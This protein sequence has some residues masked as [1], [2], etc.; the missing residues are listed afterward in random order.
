MNS[1]N[2]I[3]IKTLMFA[4]L[5]KWKTMVAV[6]V[7]LAIALGGFQGY[8]TW[9]SITDPHMLAQQQADYENTLK[10]YEKQYASLQVQME[11]TRDHVWAQRDYLEKSILMRIDPRNVY[12]ARLSLF[13]AADENA[14][15]T[16]SKNQA[17]VLAYGAG[18]TDHNVLETV[19]EQVGLE[20]KYLW[21]LIEVSAGEKDGDMSHILSVAVRHS[22]KESAELI[23]E[24]LWG[25]LTEIGKTVRINI[26]KH[27][28]S[29]VANSI[30]VMVDAELAEAQ[31]LETDRLSQYNAELAAL[32]KEQSNLRKPAVVEFSSAAVVKKAIT[33]AVVGAVLGIFLV[34]VTAWVVFV[35]GDKVYSGIGIS[36]DIVG[37]GIQAYLSALNKIIYEEEME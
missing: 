37:A 20:T 24:A 9:V 36:T 11:T 1:E 22:E 33:F 34:A 15:W 4:T 12:T 21:E 30:G 32:E 27:S 23:M 7:L 18:L 5:R 25:Q 13:I 29:V 2:G 17:M 26:G 28:V 31:R 8:K 35:T 19:A 14:Q 3:S 10:E 16:E 6:A